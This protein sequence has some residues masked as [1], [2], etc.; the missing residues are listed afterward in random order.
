MFTTDFQSVRC[1]PEFVTAHIAGKLLTTHVREKNEIPIGPYY[2]D[3]SYSKVHVMML[4]RKGK[5][6]KR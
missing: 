5:R 6:G 2:M 1:P 4:V 3:A